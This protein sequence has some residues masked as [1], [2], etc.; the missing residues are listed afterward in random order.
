MMLH[1]QLVLDARHRAIPQSQLRL[2]VP[3]DGLVRLRCSANDLGDR[4]THLVCGFSGSCGW[5]MRAADEKNQRA[6]ARSAR[7]EI[8]K[9]W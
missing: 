3:H 5:R 6:C 8:P 7:P 2:S 1:V 4:G 9:P